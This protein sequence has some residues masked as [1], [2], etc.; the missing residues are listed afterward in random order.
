[1]ALWTSGGSWSTTESPKTSSKPRKKKSGKDL[2]ARFAA[3]GDAIETEAE[4]ELFQIGVLVKDAAS[5]NANQG[6]TGNLKS[7][8]SVR[9]RHRDD[10]TPIAVVGTLVPYATYIEFAKDIGGHPY[11]PDAETPRALYKAR[12][13]KTDDIVE[14]IAAA[15]GRGL[16]AV[17]GA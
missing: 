15:V 4:K 11:L 8:Y 10:G 6:E 7:G 1:M 16:G 5:A 13:E 12:D 9:M 2:A 3:I 17:E 14:R